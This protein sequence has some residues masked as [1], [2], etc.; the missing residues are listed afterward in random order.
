MA[1]ILRLVTI[2]PRVRKGRAIELYCHVGVDSGVGKV[3][4]YSVSV[5]F[6]LGGRERLGWSDPRAVVNDSSVGVC[7][8]SV[9]GAEISSAS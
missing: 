8:T 7:E 4:D 2:G 5:G 6:I 1:R 9:S 3:E